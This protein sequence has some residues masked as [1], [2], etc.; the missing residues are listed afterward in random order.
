V[1]AAIRGFAAADGKRE[2]RPI[3]TGNCNPLFPKEG[4]SMKAQYAIIAVILAVLPM[5]ARGQDEVNVTG[6]V[7]DAAGKPV[8]GA[9]DPKMLVTGSAKD[10]PLREAL[11]KLLGPLGVDY[12][13]RD[14]VIVLTAKPK[15][16]AGK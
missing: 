2:N 3:L 4:M 16:A 14:E 12:T 10:V 11:T 5:A 7:V 13:F 15:S 6:R 1:E 9:L 8:A